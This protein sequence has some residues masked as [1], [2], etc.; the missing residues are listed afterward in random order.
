MQLITPK[1]DVVLRDA[2]Q[3]SDH[4][5]VD[6]EFMRESTYFAQLCLVQVATRDHIICVDPLAEGD[7]SA[8]WQALL[9]CNWVLHSGRQD[10]EV[11]YQATGQMPAS[12]FDTQVAMGLLGA[13]PQLGYAALVQELFNRELPKSHTRADWSKRPLSDAMLHYAA[14]DVEYLLG[15]YDLLGERLEALGRADWAREDSMLLLERSLYDVDADSAVQRLKGAGKL[16]GR[17]RRAAVALATW[18]E[19]QALKSNRPRR[20]ILK[21]AVL[22]ELAQKDARNERELAAINDMP[23]STAR[24][25]ARDLLGLLEAARN[26]SDSYVPPALPDA[27]QKALLKDLQKLVAATAAELDVA[28]EVVA[29]RKELVAAIG[30]DRRCRVFSGWRRQLIGEQLLDKLP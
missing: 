13:A 9:G 1:D 23:A 8:A 2:L 5:G 6:T 4:V 21:D 16:S 29:P 27:E 18:R 25:S 7:F 12:V 30:G 26:G 20:W 19:Q 28:A 15:A 10:I 3:H 22:L 11:V 17:A 14:E 24:R